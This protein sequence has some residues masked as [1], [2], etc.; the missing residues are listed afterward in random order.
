MTGN[1]G[2]WGISGIGG[3]RRLVGGVNGVLLFDGF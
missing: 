2:M 1:E 3:L